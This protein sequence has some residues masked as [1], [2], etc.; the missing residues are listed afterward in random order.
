MTDQLDFDFVRKLNLTDSEDFRALALT[1]QISYQNSLTLFTGT[2]HAKENGFYQW[3]LHN[4][5]DQ[6]ALWIDQNQN[7]FFET[8]ERLLHFRGE[9]LSN[10]VTDSIDLE[11]GNYSIAIY[12]A[13]STGTP[14][15]EVRFST[16]SSNSGPPSSRPYIPLQSTKTTYFLFLTNPLS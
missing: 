12:H 6:S 1:N 14:S 5:S 4:T 10:L 8:E 3:E 16:L 2:F 13:I 15:I 7:G 9:N 11:E